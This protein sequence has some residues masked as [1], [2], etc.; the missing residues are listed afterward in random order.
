M[1]RCG[2]TFDENSVPPWTR[3]GLQGVLGA[4]HNLARV[5]DRGTH[6]AAPPP[7]LQGGDFLR[8][9]DHAHLLHMS[10]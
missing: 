9:D 10:P 8:S 5:V 7:P 1:P 2:A 4:P 6:P 3:G